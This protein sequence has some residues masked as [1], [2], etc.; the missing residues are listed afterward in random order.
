MKFCFGKFILPR[1]YAKLE[2][3]KNSYASDDMEI[4]CYRTPSTIKVGKY[5][6]IGSCKFVVDGD[7]NIKYATTYPL[8][9][10]GLSPEAP[11][12]KNIKSVPIVGNDVWIGDESYIYGGVIIHDGAVVAGNSVVTK[13]VPPYAVV[14]G[15][16]ARI[17]KHRFDE[18][19]IKRFIAVEWWDLPESFVFD[20]LGPL[21][22]DPEK[23]LEAAEQCRYAN[24]C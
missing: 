24:T 22:S 20:T 15:N 12:N 14:A 9:E 18:E 10:F 6:S 2:M 11:E 1:W 23:F 21:I 17:V 5:S 8:K 3:D 19:L 4:R 13:D 16:P 7:H